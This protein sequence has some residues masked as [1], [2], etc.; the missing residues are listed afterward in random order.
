MSIIQ[1]DAPSLAKTL[2][3]ARHIVDLDDKSRVDCFYALRA[4]QR[5]SRAVRGFNHL[6]DHPDYRP[7][8]LAALSCLG[9]DARL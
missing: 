9:F 3:L 7:V 2:E 1:A 4:Q 6:L 5:L 8:G